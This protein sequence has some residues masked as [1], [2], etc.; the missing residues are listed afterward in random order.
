MA[1]V[2]SAVQEKGGSGKTTLLASL[3]ASFIRD[4]A[5]VALV[6]TDPQ[7]NLYQWAAK[8]KIQADFLAELDDTRLTP[9]LQQLRPEYDVVI[10]DTA[11]FKSTMAVYAIA[12]SDLVLIPSKA[13]ETDAKGAL[14]TFQ[15]VLSVST[16]LGKAVTTRLVMMD[17][18]QTTNITTA[19]LNAFDNAGVPRL[20][21]LCAHR[22]GFKE[23][24]SSGDGPNGSAKTA[25]LQV[26]AELQTEGLLD[27]YAKGALWVKSA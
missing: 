5:K 25:F 8:E 9:T 11:G 15:H 26:L 27:F 3:A 22:T 4:G 20:K 6:D 14:K 23:M 12:A 24:F 10:L 21:S 7:R 13:T 18:D 2:I 19:V 17:I 1:Q 16:A